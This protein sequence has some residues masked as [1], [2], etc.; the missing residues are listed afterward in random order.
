[1]VRRRAILCVGLSF[2]TARAPL[3]RVPLGPEGPCVVARSHWLRRSTRPTSASSTSHLLSAAD[4]G[5]RSWQARG[6]STALPTRHL[7]LDGLNYVN[8]LTIDCIERAS[9]LTESPSHPGMRISI[10][11][12][13][14][15]FLEGLL[16]FDATKHDSQCIFRCW[17]VYIPEREWIRPS[18]RRNPW[19]YLWKSQ[20][21]YLSHMT[22]LKRRSRARAGWVAGF[23]STW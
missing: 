11:N 16:I 5:G 22:F 15:L 3:S 1:M 2:R 8:T 12:E 13:N 14:V 7:T 20:G 19:H 18:A 17:C 9:R 4:V 10:E 6:T 23:K 21:G